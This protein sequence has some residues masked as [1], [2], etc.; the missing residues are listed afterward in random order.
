MTGIAYGWAPITKVEDQPDGTVIVHGP[1]TSADLDRDMQRFSQDF[2]DR[3]VPQWFNESGNI[4][5]QHD[6]KRAVGNALMVKRDDNGVWNCAAHVVDPVAV[7][8]VRNKVLK[9]FSIGVKSPHITYGKADAPA[10]EIDDG[11]ICE[12][13]LVDRPSNPGMIFQIVKAD[14]DTAED[15]EF[16]PGDGLVGEEGGEGGEPADSIDEADGDATDEPDEADDA[17]A[18]EG[19]DEP[20][21][22]ADEPDLVKEIRHAPAG[23][24]QGGQFMPGGTDE[25]SG[26]AANRKGAERVHV[27]GGGGKTGSKGGGKKAAPKKSAAGPKPK[28]VSHASAG[29][30]KSLHK[31]MDALGLK[32]SPDAPNEAEVKALQAKLGLPQDGMLTPALMAKASEATQ[33][34]ARADRAAAAEQ[35]KAAAAA[36]AAEKAKA[37]QQKKAAQAAARHKAD[38]PNGDT[39]GN[40]PDGPVGDGADLSK[41]VSA[42]QRKQYADSGVAMPNGDFPI[43]DEGH[44]RSAVGRLGNYQGDKAAAKKHIVKRARALGLVDALPDDWGVSKG[45]EVLEQLDELGLYKADLGEADGEVAKYDEADDI[46]GAEQAIACIAAL[47]QSEAEELALGRPEEAVDIEI[48]LRAIDALQWFKAR[49]QE[50]AQVPDMRDTASDDDTDAVDTPDVVADTVKVD[51]PDTGKTDTTPETSGAPAPETPEYVT[52]TDVANLVKAAVAEANAASEERIKTLEA[53]LAKALAQPQPGG[54][55]LTRTAAQAA[56]ARNTDADQMRAEAKALLA[57][58]DSLTHEDST[59]AAGYRE[60][61]HALLAKADA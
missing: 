42:D 32:H 24:P 31:A 51:T 30:I 46:A 55:V 41:A 1:M 39:M 23:S 44:L 28:P 18:G 5:E 50:Q 38:N 26:V 48:L 4:R 35:R 56:A 15:L 27:S 53:D 17:G 54:P 58:A 36:K 3:A 9:G 13:S 34:K 37:A 16:E 19:S 8:K 52:K 22:K 2:L 6:P 61:A 60:R 7:A 43:P 21:E 12:N 49:E 59:L 25:P 45:D 14:G 47:I 40:E 57:K 29:E 11:I 33:A 10:G 20:A